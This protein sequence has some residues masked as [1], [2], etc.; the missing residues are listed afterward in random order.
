MTDHANDP[1]SQ[2]RRAPVLRV[3]NGLLQTSKS[4]LGRH[5]LEVGNQRTLEKRS[6]K[7]DDLLGQTFA[8]FQGDIAYTAV[9]DD[10]IVIAGKEIEAL[11]FTDIVQ[12]AAFQTSM[13]F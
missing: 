9:S 2:K 6:Q 4:S 10:Q 11:H 5:C 3:V 8:D 1:H 7:P 12:G 13:H